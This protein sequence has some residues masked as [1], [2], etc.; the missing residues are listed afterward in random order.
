MDFTRALGPLAVFG[1]ILSWAV[2]VLVYR[3]DFGA[4]RFAPTHAIDITVNQSRLRKSLFATGLMLV[5]LFLGADVPLAA[6]LAAAV[7]LISRR[8]DPAGVFNEIDWSLL[9][10]FS[11]L[12]VVTGAIVHSGFGDHLFR[13]LAPYADGGAASLTGAAVILSNVVSNVPAVMLFRPIIPGVAAPTDAWLT[14]AMATTFAGN[15]TLIG[16]VA[17]LIVAE[18]ARGRGVHLTFTEYLK[19]GTPIAILSLLGGIAW[20]SC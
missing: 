15:L 10:F 11:S 1:L 20:M 4:E 3:K 7:L 13:V 18:I 12:F 16:S 5:T 9:V 8:T 6:A 14:L 19:A 17:N 2:I